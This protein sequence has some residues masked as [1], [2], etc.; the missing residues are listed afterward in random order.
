MISAEKS[1]DSLKEIPLCAKKLFFS[2]CLLNFLSLILESFIIICLGEACS[3]LKVWSYLLASSTWMSKSV[4]RLGS[5][6][7]L[8]LQI[9]FLPLFLSIFFFLSINTYMAY[10]IDFH[11]SCKLYSLFLF[12][13][14]LLP[15]FYSDCMIS[16]D[17][18]FYP[19][20]LS[21][22]FSRLLLKLSIEVFISVTVFLNSSIAVF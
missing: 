17:L 5:S 14:I 22:A 21:S 13:F 1:T 20:I 12:Y 3:G 10:F 11:N 8:F 19:L 6:Q 18:P 4:P 9:S 15:F 16:N 7:V 2:Y